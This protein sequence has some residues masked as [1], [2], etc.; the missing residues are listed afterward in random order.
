LRSPQLLSADA[1]VEPTDEVVVNGDH[2]VHV[3]L[4]S[5]LKED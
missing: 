3:F 2:Q 5:A 1:N 4:V